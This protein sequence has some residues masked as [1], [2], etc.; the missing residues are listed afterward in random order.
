M[1]FYKSI[2]ESIYILGLIWNRRLDWIYEDTKVIHDAHAKTT[3]K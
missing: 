1:Y 3:Y 2:F